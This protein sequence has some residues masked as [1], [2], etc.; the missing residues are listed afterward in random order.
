MMDNE[1]KKK[2]KSSHRDHNESIVVWDSAAFYTINVYNQFKKVILVS[3]TTARTY[4]LKWMDAD[5]ADDALKHLIYSVAFQM[6]MFEPSLA[7][8]RCSGKVAL[9]ACCFKSQS[10]RPADSDS[11]HRLMNA[12]LNTYLSLKF[13]QKKTKQVHSLVI[14]FCHVPWIETIRKLLIMR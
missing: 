13:N 5:N 6:K 2:K 14:N 12:L 10:D 4:S 3:H 9:S 11:L 8:I 7:K 1:R